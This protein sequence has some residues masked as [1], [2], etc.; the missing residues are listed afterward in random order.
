MSQGVK[1]ANVEHAMDAQED[2]TNKEMNKFY[3][4]MVTN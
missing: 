1:C 4:Q 2:S 3:F